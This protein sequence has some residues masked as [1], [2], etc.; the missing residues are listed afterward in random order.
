MDILKRAEGFEALAQ[1]IPG[2]KPGKWPIT[3]RNPSEEQDKKKHWGDSDPSLHEEYIPVNPKS[4]VID[5]SISAI[6]HAIKM[7]TKAADDLAK[8]PAGEQRAKMEISIALDTLKE[9]LGRLG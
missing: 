5:A 9:V 3:V 7:A 4:L 1:K 6:H 8:G 2:S